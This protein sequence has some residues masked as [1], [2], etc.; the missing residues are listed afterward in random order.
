MALVFATSNKHKF[1]EV[2]AVL[3][4]HG[5]A[6][7]MRGIELPEID[8]S[9]IEKIAEHKARQAYTAV[10][11][12]VIVEDTG[13]YFKAYKDFPG[14]HAKWAFETL[15]YKGFFKL[16]NGADKSAFMKTVI[17]FFDRES[18]PVFFSGEMHGK[19][20]MKVHKSSAKLMPYE[21]IFVPEGYKKPVAYLSREEKNKI[22]HRGKAAEKLAEFLEER[23]LDSIIDSII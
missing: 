15:G 21:R 5:I 1:E 13:V 19:I 11:S 4:E 18:K 10:R 16:L 23:K 3:S 12:A 22:S 6:L 20:V 9:S 14:I 2:N 17:C 7:E 8:A